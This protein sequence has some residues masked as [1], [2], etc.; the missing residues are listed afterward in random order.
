MEK[1]D[2]NFTIII[3]GTRFIVNLKQADGAKMTFEELIKRLISNKAQNLE[4]DN[5]ILITMSLLFSHQNILY[6]KM[7]Y[8]NIC[9]DRALFHFIIQFPN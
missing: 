6:R 7:P 3:N 4:N 1:N 8:L 2:F 9:Q 5:I